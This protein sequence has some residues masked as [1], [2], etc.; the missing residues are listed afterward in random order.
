MTTEKPTYSKM[1]SWADHCSSDEESDDGLHPARLAGL[2]S[3]DNDNGLSYDESIEHISVN[4]DDDDDDDAVVGDIGHGG[5]D[6]GGRRNYNNNNNN[7][8]KEIPFPEW[9]DLDRIPEDFPPNGPYVAYVQNLSYRID[10]PMA[11]AEK[12]EG[13]TRWRYHKRQEVK[14][15]SA[16]FGPRKGTAFIS[17]ATPQEVSQLIFIFV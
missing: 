6:G 2:S 15:T 7:Q 12:L 3:G 13:M 5:N 4:G 1:K 16:K 11:L 14:V 17:F 10:T 8:Q 9:I